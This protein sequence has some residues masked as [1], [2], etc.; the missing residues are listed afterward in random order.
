MKRCRIYFLWSAQIATHS[1]YWA[2]SSQSFGKQENLGKWVHIAHRQVTDATCVQ[3]RTL[4]GLS[5]WSDWRSV[6]LRGAAIA[7]EV[8]FRITV[9]LATPVA[10]ADQGWWLKSDEGRE[11]IRHDIASTWMMNVRLELKPHY[12]SARPATCTRKK[13]RYRSRR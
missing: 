8:I 9:M 5:T 11:R 6:P 7:F 10:T 2:H 4:F 3:Q 1:V 12:F 13:W